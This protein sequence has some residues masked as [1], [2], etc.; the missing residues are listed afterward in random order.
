MIRIVQPELAT[1]KTQTGFD[2]AFSAFELPNGEIWIGKKDYL[3]YKLSLD[4]AIKETDLSK[5]SGRLSFALS[6]K[7]FNQPVRIE[8]PQEFKTI[9]EIMNGLF[10]GLKGFSPVNIP[11][12][13]LPSVNQPGLNDPQ[14]DS[15]QDGL[16]LEQEAIYGTD[17]YNSDT[18]ND[19]FKDGD[20]VKN[21]YNPNGQGKMIFPDF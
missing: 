12:V 10:G 17:P 5:T 1:E 4:L 8:A 9:E 19:G 18:D 11:G 15:D 2:K 13:S 21:G 14:A 3:P 6:L 7:N 20:E 16:N